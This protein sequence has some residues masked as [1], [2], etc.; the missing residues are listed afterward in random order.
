MASM[1]NPEMLKMARNMM[2]TNPDLIN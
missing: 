2:Q 1:M